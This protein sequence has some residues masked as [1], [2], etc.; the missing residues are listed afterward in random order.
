MEARPIFEMAS[1]RPFHFRVIVMVLELD[2]VCLRRS[3]NS[4]WRQLQVLEGRTELIHGIEATS[5]QIRVL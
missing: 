2:L 4:I 5:T 3:A 1:L